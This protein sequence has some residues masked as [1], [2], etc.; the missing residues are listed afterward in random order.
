MNY[1]LNEGEDKSI[2]AV[3][4][5]DGGYAICITKYELQIT[6]RN[7]ELAA[8]ELKADIKKIIN[9]KEDGYYWHNIFLKKN[10]IF[11]IYVNYN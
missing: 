3:G 1:R 2:Y 8:K 11:T 5:T 9:C 4:F 10:I 7:I 6:L